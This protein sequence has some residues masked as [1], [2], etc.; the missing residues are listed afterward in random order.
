MNDVELRNHLAALITQL[1]V[2]LV[3]HPASIQVRFEVGEATTVFCIDTDP[4]NMGQIIGTHGKNINSLRT[5]IAAIAAKN[6]IRAIVEIPYFDRP[7][8]S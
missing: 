3:D 5:I 1:V 6:N 4:R 2:N 7:A 8:V